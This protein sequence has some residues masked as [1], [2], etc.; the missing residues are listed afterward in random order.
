MLKMMKESSKC[1]PSNV[2]FQDKQVIK[3][4]EGL[5]PLKITP[6]QLN[7]QTLGTYAIPECSTDFTIQMIK[8]SKPKNF[9]DLIRISGLS[10]GTEV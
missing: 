4:F 10:H 1:D 2:D 6:D 5:E 9:G 3:L 8:D 7:G